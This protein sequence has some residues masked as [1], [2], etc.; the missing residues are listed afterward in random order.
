MDDLLYYL[1]YSHLPE[2]LLL[3]IYNYLSLSDQESVIVN[4]AIFVHILRKQGDIKTVLV[5]T[6]F[7]LS[8]NHVAVLTS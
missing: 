7:P 6:G 3:A 1:L 2:A 4:A 5:L 8:L